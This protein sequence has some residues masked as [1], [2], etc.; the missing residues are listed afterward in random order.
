MTKVVE[1][2]NQYRVRG[3]NSWTS[4]IGLERPANEVGVFFSLMRILSR[5]FRVALMSK[6]AVIV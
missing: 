3:W 6:N 4:S 1:G 2:T 5:P